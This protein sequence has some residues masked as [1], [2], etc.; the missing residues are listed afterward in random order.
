M[1]KNSVLKSLIAGG[2]FLTIFATILQV[3]EIP[4]SIMMET[5]FCEEGCSWNATSAASYQLCY[6]SDSFDDAY[7]LSLRSKLS[8]IKD[9]HFPMYLQASYAVYAN[10][11]SP[12]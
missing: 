2:I 5:I 6:P 7:L 11:I 10:K 8:N 1:S 9:P 12:D 4:Q 3:F